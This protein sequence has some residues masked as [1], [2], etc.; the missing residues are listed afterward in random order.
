[1]PV[2]TFE[3]GFWIPRSAP[4]PRNEVLKNGVRTGA[5]RGFTRKEGQPESFCR[6]AGPR[7]VWLLYLSRAGGAT[8]GEEGGATPPR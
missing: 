8:G 4:R 6:R 1:M 3:R 7:G 2:V 5:R